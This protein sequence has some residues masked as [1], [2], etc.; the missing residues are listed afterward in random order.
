M[1][2][3]EFEIISTIGKQ[4]QKWASS[5]LNIF[6]MLPRLNLCNLINITSSFKADFDWL[7]CDQNCLKH[8]LPLSEKLTFCTFR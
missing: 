2:M 7:L 6:E 1:S 8:I 5:A 4:G 3:K